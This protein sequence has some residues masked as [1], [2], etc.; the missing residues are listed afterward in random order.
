MSGWI[1]WI[2][3]EINCEKILFKKALI[4]HVFQDVGK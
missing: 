2:E 4:C 3:D 1:N